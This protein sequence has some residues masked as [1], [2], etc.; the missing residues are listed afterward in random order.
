MTG[1]ARIPESEREIVVP[2][3][4]SL[5]QTCAPVVWGKGRWPSVAWI[6]GALY[7]VG[8][9]ND[10]VSWR[11]VR[12]P[13]RGVL[14]LDG[15]RDD[16]RD[17]SWLSDSLGAYRQVASVPDTVI[18]EIAE[19]FPGVRPHCSGSLFN[20][21]V[22]CIAGQ[23][24]TVAAAAITEARIAALFHP[25]VEINGRMFWPA[26]SADQLASADPGLVRTSGV[27]WKRAEAIVAAANAQLA[28]DLPSDDEARGFPD[29]ARVALRKL[30]L[31]GAW[32]AESALLWGL[33]IDDAFP[34]NDA[35]L[36]RAARQ[37]Y[38]NPELDHRGLDGLAEGWRPWRAWAARWLWTELLGVPPD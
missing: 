38:G 37:A 23:S 28:G 35:A 14:L 29:E 31:V 27:T 18:A 25:G 1:A 2:D 26:P 15:K 4:F 9:E 5:A 8:V 16:S 32:T 34:P 6:E 30:Q 22:T 36:L 13:N 24:I 10:G 20:G 7:W 17:E 11:R 12:Q 3:S 21:I 19:R 33:G